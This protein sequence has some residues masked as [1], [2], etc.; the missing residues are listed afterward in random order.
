MADVSS[1]TAESVAASEPVWISIPQAARLLGVRNEIVYSLVK[2]G[3][4][5]VKKVPGCHQRLNRREILELITASIQPAVAPL[6]PG[7]FA[8]T[9]RKPSA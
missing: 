1:Y 2:H 8:G 7:H 9:S 4:L 3:R 5:T 6:A